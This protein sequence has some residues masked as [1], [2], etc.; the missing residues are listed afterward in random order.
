LRY[1]VN[2][3]QKLITNGIFFNKSNIKVFFNFFCC[4]APAKAFILKIKRHTGFLSCSKF[5]IKGEYRNNRVCLPYSSVE[6]LERTHQSYIIRL[7]EDHHT[8]TQILFILS[9]LPNI[10][11]VNLCLI[12][13]M[14][15][16]L[17]GVVKKLIILWMSI[18]SLNVRIRAR[19]VQKLSE[20]L[21]LLNQY[22]TSDFAR[23]SELSDVAR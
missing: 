16:V 21:L 8:S 22:M 4:D 10:N 17:L 13:Y 14:H 11:L 6:S 9:E 23:K 18:G 15:L 7:D 3:A 12:D 2:E 19:H 5:C 1:F 20:R